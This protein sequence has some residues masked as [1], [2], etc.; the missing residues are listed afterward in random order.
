MNTASR[1]VVIGESLVDLVWHPGAD[2]VRPVPGGSPANVAT[3]LRRLGRPVI[4]VT[5]WGDDPPGELVARWLSGT[6][7]DVVRAPSA[8]ART[9]VA[10]AYV[11]AVSGSATYDFVP[12]WDPVDLPTADGAALVHTGSLAAV[13]APGADSVLEVCERL[14]GR[15]GCAVSADLNVRPAVQP[16]RAL[17]RAAVERLA[18]VT[19]VVKAS[20]EDLRWLWPDRDPGRSARALLALGPRLVVLTRGAKGASAYTGAEG[21]EVSVAAPPV[22]VVDTIGAGDAFQSAL[23]DGLLVAEPGVGVSVRLPDTPQALRELLVR[24]VVAGALATT[25]PGAQPPH[26][27]ELMAALENPAGR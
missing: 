11:D 23:L 1:V 22:Q 3:G 8:S 7:L 6:G 13:L 16:D 24:S 4:L 2:Q 27:K 20:D 10:L 9:T 12:H 5:C 26:A 14:H 25:R 21:T 15:P 18:T 19:D 17:Y